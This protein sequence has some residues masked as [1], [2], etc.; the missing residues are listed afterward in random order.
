MKATLTVL[1]CAALAGCGAVAVGGGT[2]LVTSDVDAAMAA[3]GAQLSFGD[4]A[5]TCGV[6]SAAMGTAVATASGYT[7][8]D[9]SPGSTALRTHYVDGFTDGC[10][11]QFT[12][13][14]VLTG[15]V[16][17]HEAVRYA[18][19]ASEQRYSQTD[20]AYEAIKLAFCR[21]GTGERC[22]DR[23]D[24]LARRTVFLTAYPQF[25]DSRSWKE[26]LLHEGTVAG[27]GTET[28]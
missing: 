21:V 19:P 8:Y 4:I 6:S 2:P 14:L 9:T 25:T 15:D 3:P 17:T 10:A 12:A 28:P 20:T 23:I 16:D 13:A 18:R 22:G 27:S 24:V 7:V 1:V 26:F 11:R 5:T